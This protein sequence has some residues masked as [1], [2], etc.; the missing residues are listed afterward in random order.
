MKVR[1]K[2]IEGDLEL[3]KYHTPGSVGFDFI[4]RESVAIKPKEIVLLKTNVIIETPPG[5]ML[6]VVARSST[7]R[8][9][10]LIVP[11]GFGVIDQDYCGEEDEVLVQVYNFTDKEVMVEKGERIAQ[12]VFV[13]VE[14]AEWEQSNVL[15]EVS[16]GGI[17]STGL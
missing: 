5:Y 17:G 2:K 7:A 11:N 15:G 4:I 3:P 8:K 14:R 10:G 9:K 12:G 13:K 16:R 6:A 1:I